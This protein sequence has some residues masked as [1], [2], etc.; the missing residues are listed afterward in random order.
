MRAL[1]FVFVFLTS[2]GAFA[3]VKPFRLT[4]KLVGSKEFKF[5]YLFDNETRL[6]QRVDI[7]NKEFVAEGTYNTA[8]RFWEPPYINLLLSNQDA[9]IEVILSDRPL[10]RRRYDRCTIICEAQMEA[11]YN[12]ENRMFSIEGQETNQLQNKFNQLDVQFLTKRDSSNS[13][14]AQMTLSE[15]EKATLQESKAR[16]IYNNILLKMASLIK[17]HPDAEVS[18]FNFGP[19]LYDQHYTAANTAALFETLSERIKESPYAAQTK[20]EVD[21]KLSMEDAMVNPPYTVGM[22]FPEFILE[23]SKGEQFNSTNI[24]SKLTL[25]DFWA[26]W[27]APCR[28]ETPNVVQAYK[29]FH[30]QGFQVITISIDEIKDKD[31]WTDALKQDGMLDFVNLFNGGD[32]SGLATTLKIVTIPTNYLIDDQGKIIAM[33]LRGEALTNFLS[34]RH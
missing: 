34:D 14:I 30:D 12:S 2:I 10:S 3:E 19:I 31:K 15:S 16:S 27:C 6:I 4:F 24:S 17:Q 13:S 5:A 18:L 1:L 28:K 33:N 20:I 7:L 23:S 32:L 22:S 21:H 11:V 25:I 26:T 9:P 8:Q 29:K